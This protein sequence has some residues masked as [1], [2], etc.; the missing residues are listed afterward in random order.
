MDSISSDI[1][2]HGAT[3]E[4]VRMLVEFVRNGKDS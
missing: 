2:E 4:P 1:L 3:G